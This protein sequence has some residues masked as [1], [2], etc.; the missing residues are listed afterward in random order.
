MIISVGFIFLGACMSNRKGRVGIL[1]LLIGVAGLLPGLAGAHGGLALAEDQCK[2]SLG[3]YSM[4][5]TGYQPD[6]EGSKEF[7]EDIPDIGRTVVALDAIDDVLR[8][9]PIEVRL[10]KDTGDLSNLEPITILHMPPKVY[11]AGSVTFE[12]V[13][14]KPG[15]FVGIVTAM[16]G[17]EAIVSQF[18]FSVGSGGSTFMK[19]LPFLG[20]LVAGGV[21]YW[22]STV[23][24]SKKKAKS[25]TEK[26]PSA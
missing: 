17:K 5:F 14:D 12:Y 20:I 3:P 25:A 11:S 2:L 19:Y 8:A 9:M 6:S 26:T 15:K 16:N 22:Y 21:L 18:P 4:H 7:C 23:S 24:Q 10:V 1:V 13:F